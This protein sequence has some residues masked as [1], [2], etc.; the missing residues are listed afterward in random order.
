MPP[1]NPTS[2]S[3]N[4]L[5]PTQFRFVHHLD[6]LSESSRH[7]HRLGAGRRGS[8]CVRPSLALWGVLLYAS[9]RPY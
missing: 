2:M 8:Q 9:G 3:S 7:T 4:V 6:R 1:A 5:K